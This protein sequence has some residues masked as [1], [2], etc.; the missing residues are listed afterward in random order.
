MKLKEFL[1]KNAFILLGCSLALI[2]RW[3]QPWAGTTQA[4]LPVFSSPV[5]LLIVVLV[6]GWILVAAFY[7]RTR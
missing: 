3:A 6:I 7:V 2:F 4:R 1:L 5:F